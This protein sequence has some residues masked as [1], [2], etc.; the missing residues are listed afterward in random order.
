MVP[1]M[2]EGDRWIAEW[3]ARPFFR[4]PGFRVV[5]ARDGQARVELLVEE[6][7]RGG[8]GTRAVNGGIVAYLFDGLL[9]AAVFSSRDDITGQVTVSLNITYLRMLEAERQVVG[10]ARVISGGRN[11]VFAQGEVMD[12]HGN[13]C[14]TCSGIYRIFTDQRG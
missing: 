3:N 12:E 6:H 11:L 13:V 10:T 4:W 9:G 2:R 5:E 14:A 1:G 7:H 8:G